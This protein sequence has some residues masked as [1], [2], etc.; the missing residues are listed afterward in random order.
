[1]IN[2]KHFIIGSMATLTLM[3]CGETGSTVQTSQDRETLSLRMMD[4][5]QNLSN[6]EAVAKDYEAL[7]LPKYAN[8]DYTLPSE[9]IAGSDINWSL[10]NVGDFNITNHTLMIEDTSIKQYAKL[11]A[12]I[13]YDLNTSTAEANK[14]KEFCLTILPEAVTA[15]EKVA[16]DIKMIQGNHFPLVIDLNSTLPYENCGLIDVSPYND[17]NITWIICDTDLLEVN[18]TT[19]SFQVVNPEAIMYKTCTTVKGTFQYGDVEKVDYFKVVIFPLKKMM[20][21]EEAC[22]LVKDAQ[23]ALKNS[24]FDISSTLPFAD[25][26]V[27]ISW[28]SCKPE[29]LTVDE[30]GN[31][32]NNNTSGEM[33]KV[34]IKASLTLQDIEK[35]LYIPISVPAL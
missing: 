14:T 28:V 25:G 19:N 2:Y 10:M 7:T 24:T 34:Y 26:D 15:M 31:F 32:V 17:S 16:Q 30:D 20:S 13:N 23:E 5:G 8:Q 22:Q 29:Y 12:F 6:Q 11:S 27:S 9:G 33:Q 4:I 18:T 1:M 21:Y 35:K 3:G